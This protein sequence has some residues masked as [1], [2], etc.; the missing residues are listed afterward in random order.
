MPELII[1]A[2]GTQT[3]TTEYG[4]IMEAADRYQ[5]LVPESLHGGNEHVAKALVRNDPRLIDSANMVVSLTH[6]LIDGYYRI[7]VQ[8]VRLNDARRQDNFRL[9]Y[10]T[11][12]T[13][14]PTAIDANGLPIFAEYD[15]DVQSTTLDASIPIYEVHCVGIRDISPIGTPARLCALWIGGVNNAIFNANQ[16]AGIGAGGLFCA[17][18]DCEP[19]Y[20]SAD[21]GAQVYRIHFRFMGRNDGWRKFV[22]W[23]DPQ[24]G[25]PP[26]GID[27][28]EWSTLVQLY[29]EFDFNQAWPFGDDVA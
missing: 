1:K 9:Y 17:G 2:I 20:I 23:R 29:K 13:S 26:P 14:E 7:E 28:V 10:R 15:G 8:R 27:P 19:H 3:E 11:G 12:V 25:M 21:T 6:K 22:Y 5:V 18:V 16:A 24:T 4:W